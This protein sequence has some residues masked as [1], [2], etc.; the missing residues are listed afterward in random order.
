MSLASMTGFGRGEAAAHGIRVTVEFSSVNRK[1]FECQISL[2]RQL[3]ALESK[4]YTLVQNGVRRGQVKGS[5]QLSMA[6]GAA[7]AGGMRIDLAR[8]EAQLAALRRAGRKLGLQDDLGITH[9]LALPDVVSFDVL[10]EDPL[11]LWPLV[12]QAAEQALEAMQRMRAR[13]GQALARDLRRRFKALRTLRNRA[14]RR[15]PRI[16]ADYRDALARR[17]ARLDS[18]VEVDP[19][20]LARELAVFADRVDV[21]E[22]LTRLES[23]L[24][25]ADALIGG[26]GEG[27]GRALDFLCQELLREIN[28]VGSKANDAQLA[29]LV[30][31][32]KSQL[33]AAREQIQNVE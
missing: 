28:T 12:Q 5:V 23:H 30:V 6:P 7:A 27:A 22:E 33:E 17:L 18:G 13:E 19:A 14:A 21:S 31:T 29:S 24:D 9:L 20:I 3:G 10:P 2:P 1:Q 15:A 26:D 16:P 8:A 25:Q 4:L 11:K 32:F